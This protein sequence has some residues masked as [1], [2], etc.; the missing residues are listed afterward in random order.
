MAPTN[1][2]NVRQTPSSGAVLQEHKVVSGRSPYE[3]LF[4]YTTEGY[5]L[6]RNSPVSDAERKLAPEQWGK[7]RQRLVRTTQAPPRGALVTDSYALIYLASAARMD[8]AGSRLVAYLQQDDRLV[9]LTFTAGGL[10]QTT[11]DVKVAG[12]TDKKTQSQVVARVVTLTGR[13]LGEPAKAE[14]Q[15]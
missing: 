5:F 9:E 12:P 10:R 4:R 3:K 13:V 11:C 8:R 14:H 6:W 15:P 1:P 7:R 2:P